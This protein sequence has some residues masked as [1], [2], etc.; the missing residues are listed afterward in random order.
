M[1]HPGIPL[2]QFE[3]PMLHGKKSPELQRFQG[4]FLLPKTST[5]M[6][7]CQMLGC[8]EFAESKMRA[9]KLRKPKAMRLRVLI[10][11]LQPS[12]KP[13]VKCIHTMPRNTKSGYSTPG[14]LSNVV[15]VHYGTHHNKVGTSRVGI[16][17]YNC[18]CCFEL[19]PIGNGS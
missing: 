11:M 1:G 2:G 3:S 19:I 18:P 12:I 15:Q 16:T 5:R 9:R 13:L 4:F 7:L 6:V 17:G 10:P 14:I 8:A